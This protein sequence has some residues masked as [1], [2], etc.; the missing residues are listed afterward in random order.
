MLPLQLVTIAKEVHMQFETTALLH[1]KP[2][3]DYTYTTI[4]QLGNVLKRGEF[5]PMME[6]CKEYMRLGGQLANLPP[7]M[8]LAPDVAAPSGG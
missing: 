4:Q 6:A 3:N 7:H 8:L 1:G 5:W 2:S